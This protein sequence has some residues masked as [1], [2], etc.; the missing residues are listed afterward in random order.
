V[1]PAR[2]HTPFN[3]SLPDPSDPAPSWLA[4]A[5]TYTG[6]PPSGSLA[7][8]GTGW[9]TSATRVKINGAFTTTGG[10]FTIINGNA[11]N[12]PPNNVAYIEI[13]VSGNFSTNATLTQQQGVYVTWYVDGSISTGGGSYT[14]QNG[15]AKYTTFNG[16]GTGSITVSGNSNF[17]GVVNAP[18]R[19]V[20]VTGSGDMSGSLAA[21]T[22]NMTG[23]GNFH[24][25]EALAALAT[26][27]TIA[28]Y[29][30]AS[31]FE[32]NSARARSQTF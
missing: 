14:N 6:T 25:D 22:L 13:W 27:T 19:D 24:Y 18:S 15:V 3:A 12:P 4:G 7:A 28:N 10:A 29:S 16:I 11:S 5:S 26:S 31:W 17:I 9:G 20:T 8:T 21:N 1:S 23:S 2:F 30:F 32:D